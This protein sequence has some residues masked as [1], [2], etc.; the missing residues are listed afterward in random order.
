MSFLGRS[1]QGGIC[2]R[3]I[4]S[5]RWPSGFASGWCRPWNPARS[6]ASKPSVKWV[7]PFAPSRSVPGP[8]G[9]KL[10]SRIGGGAREPY[11]QYRRHNRRAV[12]TELVRQLA[13]EAPDVFYGDHLDSLVYADLRRTIPMVLDL[14]NVYSILLQRV[15]TEQQSWW[16]RR[17]LRR[18]SKLLV[19]M[20]EQ[21]AHLV[22][23]LHTVSE[24]E[25]LY[26]EN[27]G[28]RWVKVVPNGVDCELFQELPTGRAGQPPLILYL[29]NMSWGPNISAAIFLAR[30]VMPELVEHIPDARLRIVGRSPVPEVKALARL[31]GVEVAG[32]VPDTKPH[33]RE[34]RVLA[35]PLDSG[36]GTRLKILEAFA[37]GVP[38]VSTAVGCEGIEVVHGEHLLIAERD[39]FVEGLRAALDDKG[40]G[41][42]LAAHAR[43]LARDRY[44]WKTVGDAACETVW[45]V[46]QSATR[47][48]SR[49]Q[50]PS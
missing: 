18:E 5:T 45:D 42:R 29:G 4:C 46:I 15:S 33:L 23:H 17:Y 13:I 16:K 44:D 50:R 48:T 31:P 21:A 30:E 38:V 37:A 27:L 9:E 47:S 14:H 32:D 43:E 6:P 26:F 36:G 39:Q 40:S 20:E 35:V 1:I 8:F 7:S 49:A 34:A 24:D 41:E 3:S 12:R 10:C 22:D 25:K 28:A 19:K 11:V 2:G